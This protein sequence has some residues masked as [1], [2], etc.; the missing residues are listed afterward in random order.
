MDEAFSEQTGELTLE[1][2]GVIRPESA[3]RFNVQ[4]LVRDQRAAERE[5]A[6][7]EGTHGNPFRLAD[8]LEGMV[9]SFGKRRRQR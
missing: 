6:G 3:V 7:R 5:G 4:G 2:K 8:D 9:P 1:I